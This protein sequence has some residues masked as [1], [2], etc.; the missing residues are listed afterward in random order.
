MLPG[1]L[2]GGRSR[3]KARDEAFRQTGQAQGEQ[4]IRV[5]STD[6]QLGLIVE[7]NVVETNDRLSPSAHR[8]SRPKTERGRR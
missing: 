1:P 8:G 7:A 5:L 6:L 2:R 3:R 4:P